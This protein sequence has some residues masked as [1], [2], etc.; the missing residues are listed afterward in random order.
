MFGLKPINTTITTKADPLAEM[1]K[2]IDKA[3]SQAE[4]AGVAP[5]RIRAF[6]ENFLAYWDRRAQ[7]LADLA[8]ATTRMHDQHGNPLNLD[9]AVS[10]TREKRCQAEIAESQRAHQESVARRA[11]AEEIRQEYGWQR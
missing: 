9:A 2:A 8:K 11:E 3:A 4:D 1:Q 10:V 7:H 5:A 6:A